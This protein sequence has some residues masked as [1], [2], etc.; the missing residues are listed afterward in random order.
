MDGDVAG[1]TLDGQPMQ[2]TLDSDKNVR[3]GLFG[4]ALQRDDK[5]VKFKV[6]FGGNKDRDQPKSAQGGRGG[7]RGGRGGGY[8]LIFASLAIGWR[9]AGTDS[10]LC[11]CASSR[12]KDAPSKTS[13]E[14]DNEMDTYMKDS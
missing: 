2:I 7:R 13:D 12:G 9:L 1:R 5:D 14:L 3:K 6:S 11:V 10:M 8:A 4:T